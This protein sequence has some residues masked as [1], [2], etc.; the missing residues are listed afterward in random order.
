MW[1]VRSALGGASLAV[2]VGRGPALGFPP[3]G[4]AVDLVPL[5]CSQ[6]VLGAA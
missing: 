2:L 3:G 5:P 6:A 1:V 4:S